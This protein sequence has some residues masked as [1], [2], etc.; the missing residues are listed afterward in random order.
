MVLELEQ[1]ELGEL[2]VDEIT[3]FELRDIL[4]EERGLR[5]GVEARGHEAVGVGVEVHGRR[6]DL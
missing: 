6:V 2:L 5:V 3:F 1:L 4:D